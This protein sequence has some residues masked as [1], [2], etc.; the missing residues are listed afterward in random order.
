MKNYNYTLLIFCLALLSCKEKKKDK[1]EF[2]ISAIS[3]INGQ[4]NKLDTSFY[5]IMKYDIQPGKTDTTY[6]KRE[7]VRKMASDFLSLPDITKDNYAENY[8]EE[9]MLDET[10]NTLSITA[11]AKNE[12]LEI[13]KQILI[14]PLDASAA[15]NV[16]SIF[17]DRLVQMN[18]STIEQKLFWEL[19]KYFQIGSIIQ[20]GNNPEKIKTVKVT[21]N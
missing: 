1:T 8:T 6:M 19:D 2:G 20:V 4:V 14:V 18:D 10:Q 5:Q 16:Q 21:W 11:T 15:G 9:K 13:Q 17:I 3:I 12:K 7:E